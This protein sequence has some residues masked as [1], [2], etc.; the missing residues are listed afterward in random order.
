MRP[1]ETKTNSSFENK[2]P[3]NLELWKLDMMRIHVLDSGILLHWACEL[4]PQTASTTAD[5]VDREVQG[6]QGVQ[7][8]GPEFV[9]SQSRNVTAILGR[10]ALLNCRVSG[11]S[12][13]TVSWIRHQDTHLLTAGR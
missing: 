7:G 5:C 2:I 13:K 11:V 6:V 8:V 3:D 4:N 12:N 1:L 9:R 10:P